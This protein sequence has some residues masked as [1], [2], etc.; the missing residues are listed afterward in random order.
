MKRPF[1]L[2][3]GSLLVSSLFVFPSSSQSR[4]GDASN[5]HHDESCS[6]ESLKGSY[7]FYRVGTVPVG[8]LAA[9]GISTFDGRGVFSTAQSIRKN[10]EDTG[11]LFTDGTGDAFYSVESNCTAKFINP[12]DS[13]VFAHAVIVDG[14][15]EIFFMSLS[16]HNTVTGVAKRISAGEPR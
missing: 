14:G 6:L 13:S 1:A 4:A 8:P 10:G 15:K 5:P 12:D 9:V 16:D 2:T 11:D 7:G 3:V